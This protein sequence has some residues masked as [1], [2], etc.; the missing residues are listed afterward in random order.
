MKGS[1]NGEEGDQGKF[2]WA[3]LQTRNGYNLQEVISGFQKYV[4][5]GMEREALYFG[6][7]VDLS[8]YGEYLWKRIRVIASED[9]GI[10]D[11]IVASAIQMMYQT[12]KQLKEKATHYS[13]P[14]RV[15]TMNAILMLV[16]AKKSR[17]TDHANWVFYRMDRK[18]PKNRIELADFCI[19]KHTKAG[20]EKGRGF[21]HFFEEGCKLVNCDLPDPYEEEGKS[22]IRKAESEKK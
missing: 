13:H 21:E 17:M 3:K 9:I 7:E 6:S 18:D 11:P 2:E 22:A 19:D 4:R 5:R 10:A 1:A 14:D 12:F 15:V 8:G 16:R 20:K